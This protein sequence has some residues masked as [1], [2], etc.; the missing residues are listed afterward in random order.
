MLWFAKPP[1][2]RRAGAYAGSMRE[3]ED[4]YG[5]NLAY[6]DGRRDGLDLPVGE[7]G[8]DDGRLAM[9]APKRDSSLT[10]AAVWHLVLG[11]YLV[12]QEIKSFK[13]QFNQHG[14]VG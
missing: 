2:T 14:M 11:T 10:A 3:R 7:L 8:L 1:A 5:G 6:V 12:T 9:I 4:G 13:T